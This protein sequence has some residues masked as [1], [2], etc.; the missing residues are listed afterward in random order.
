MRRTWARL[1][2]VPVLGCAL[3]CASWAAP[4]VR[5]A[6]LYH[7]DSV[8]ELGAAPWT[9]PVLTLGLFGCSTVLVV[10]F[11]AWVPRRRTWFTALGAGTLYGYLLHGFLAKGAQFGG[12]PDARPWLRAPLGEVVVTVVAALA[13]TALC[14]PPVWRVFRFAMEPTMA[15]A[16]RAV[17]A[18]TRRR[19]PRAGG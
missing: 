16:F 11:L 5:P 15:W 4:R 19:P 8:R 10:C 1:V 7:S 2:A 6:W 12:W 3:G 14:T 17:P 13:V 18:E 9:G